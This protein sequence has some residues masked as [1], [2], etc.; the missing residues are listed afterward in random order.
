MGRWGEKVPATVGT[1]ADRFALLQGRALHL[2][3]TFL[4]TQQTKASAVG[5]GPLLAQRLGLLLQEGLQGS[6]GEP[7]GGRISD[8]LHGTEIDV[9]SGSVVAEGVSGDNLAPLGGE[10]AEFL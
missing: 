2:E 4:A 9:E 6:F 5:A 10:L 7:G 8:L 1:V 3:G